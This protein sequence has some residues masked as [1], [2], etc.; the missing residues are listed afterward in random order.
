M[1]I[2]IRIKQV[3]KL[4]SNTK[5]SILKGIKTFFSNIGKLFTYGL[6]TTEKGWY[7]TNENVAVKT[8]VS[9]IYDSETKTF[10]F[11]NT[12]SGDHEIALEISQTIN[13]L[14]T[15]NLSYND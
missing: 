8:D 5:F 14:S 10:L 12:P 4:S 9:L 6:M 2:P 3:Q 15:N 13:Q 1:Q 7:I 11:R